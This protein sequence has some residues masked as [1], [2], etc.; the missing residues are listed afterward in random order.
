MSP[1]FFSVINSQIAS[2]VS[3]S[4]VPSFMRQ[5]AI[6]FLKKLIST[7]SSFTGLIFTEI[8]LNSFLQC[9]MLDADSSSISRSADLLK[10]FQKLPQF[11]TSL[12]DILIKKLDT[13]T[14]LVP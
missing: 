3:N 4:E 9:N 13:L 8:D 1:Q 6:T 14:E 11:C 2:L 10:S 5:R 7:D 12:Y